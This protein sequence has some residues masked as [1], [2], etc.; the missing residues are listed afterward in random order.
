LLV[1]LC[2]SAGGAL[3]RLASWARA[4]E[5]TKLVP[6]AVGLAALFLFCNASLGL[7]DGRGQQAGEMVLV[8]L[9]ARQDEHALAL[10]ARTEPLL[11]DRSLL[12]YRVGL[13]YLERGDVA[14]ALPFLERAQRAAPGQ[15]DVELSLGQALLANGRPADAESHLR[16]AR[17]AGVAAGESGYDLARALA[18]LGRRDEAIDALRRASASRAQALVPEHAAIGLLALSLGAP[19]LAESELGLAVAETPRSAELREA[20]GLALA[21]LARPAQARAE[22]EEALRLDPARAS[23]PFNLAVIAVREG[24]LEEA[25]RLL[26]TALRLRPDYA[27]ARD[28]LERLGREN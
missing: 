17:D 7:D 9:N 20:H 5:R 16:A 27:Q 10:L 18:G 19:D 21:Q 14:S 6:A 25:R 1:P 4:G 2:A 13:A 22:V 23:A 3:A 8:R 12:H 24:R 11:E 26:E 28:L 15:G